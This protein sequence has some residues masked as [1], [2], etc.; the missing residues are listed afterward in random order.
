[1]SDIMDAMRDISNEGETWKLADALNARIPTGLTGFQEIIDEA[2]SEGVL[3]TLKLNTLRLYRDTASRWP[4]DKRVSGVSFSVHR[5]MMVA[6][7]SKGQ[8]LSLPEQIKMIGDVQ[9]TLAAQGKTISVRSVREAIAVKQGKQTA[10]QKRATQ[11]ASTQQATPMSEVLNDIKKGAPNLIGAISPTAS[12]SELDK[13]TAG[14]NKALAHVEKLRMKIARAKQAS[15]AQKAAVPAA[16]APAAKANGDGESK[17][18]P[19]KRRGD[20]RGL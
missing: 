1:M 5:E 13:F 11:A 15:K 7:D 8:V 18:A 20:L 16:A 12:E 4:A 2:T 17:A 19:A 14:F 6:K 9:K 10:A 3:G